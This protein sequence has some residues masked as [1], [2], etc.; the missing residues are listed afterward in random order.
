MD[1]TE[2]YFIIDRL[3]TPAD[4]DFLNEKMGLS[5][6]MLFNILARKV[7]RNVLR[8]FHRIKAKQRHLLDDW[9][10]GKSFCELA[11]REGFPPVLMASFVLEAKR[12]SKKQFQQMLRNPEKVADK[13]ICAELKEVV[14]KDFVYSPRSSD[15]QRQHGK[16]A[17]LKLSEFVKRLGVEYMTEYENKAV[18]HHQRTPDFLLKKPVMVEGMK[19]HWVESKASFGSPEEMKRDYRRQLEPYVKHFGPGIVVYWYGYVED[20]ALPNVRVI[21]ENFFT[22]EQA[23]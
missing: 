19:V 2:Y 7:V 11:A 1:S 6:D 23:K 13:R 9:K 15:I 14:E 12:V 18:K 17:E 20:V 8:T 21:D 16:D 5:R 10:R 22:R 3:N 4:V